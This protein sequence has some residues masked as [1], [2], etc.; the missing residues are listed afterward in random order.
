M[1][2]QY[3]KN[4]YLAIEL[5][6]KG[7]IDSEIGKE[8]GVSRERIRQLLCTYKNESIVFCKR[9][10]LIVADPRKCSKCDN[11][12]TP[13]TRFQTTCG[14]RV[15]NIVSCSICGKPSLHKK[16]RKHTTCG[17]KDCIDAVTNKLA[18]LRR[19]GALRRNHTPTP[20]E[21]PVCH[22][23]HYKYLWLALIRKFK[24]RCTTCLQK[25]AK[26]LC[27]VCKSPS[28]S[29]T[30]RCNQHAKVSHPSLKS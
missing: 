25:Q 22:T 17:D 11:Q 28:S 7:I 27:K 15:S 10:N 16:G 19:D 20:V 1:N 2:Y 21:C 13:R 14:C 3:G 18:K 5:K 26:T 9:G 24:I 12:F 4:Y 29:K 6:N 30:G 8:L 23:R